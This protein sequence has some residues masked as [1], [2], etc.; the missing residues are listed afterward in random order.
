MPFPKFGAKFNFGTTI[1]T[2][3][4]DAIGAI[5]LYWH[6]FHRNRLRPGMN[7]SLP[8]SQ[9]DHVLQW[10]ENA[11][12]D[13]TLGFGAAVPSER[14]LA[15]QLG[16]SRNTVSA[17]MD[18]AERR[19][20][21]VTHSP[22]GRKRFVAG[23][24]DVRPVPMMRDSICV[25][26]GMGMAL[27]GADGVRLWSESLLSARLF[28]HLAAAG[29]NAMVVNDATLSESDVDRL[30]L[31]PP[32]GLL[33]TGTVNDTPLSRHI[34]R[35][36]R[37]A[38]VTAVAYGNHEGLRDMDRVYSD[39]RAGSREIVRWLIAQGCRH[40]RLFFPCPVNWHWMTERCEGY[41]EALRE[42]GLEAAPPL[43]YGPNVPFPSFAEEF[44]VARACAIATLLDLRAAGEP[45]DALVCMNDRFAKVAISALRAL[46]LDPG[47]DVLVA[48]YDNW[49][50]DDECDPYE[51][52]VPAVTLDRRSEA[53][54]IAMADLL[55]ARLDG[56]LPPEPQ[57]RVNPHRLVV[58][59]KP[60]KPAPPTRGAT[61]APAASTSLPSASAAAPTATTWGRLTPVP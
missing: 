55:L 4:I 2:F 43:V 19:G 40:I 15:L 18:E 36:C 51:R 1:F 3:G 56:R 44:R 60:P 24:D 10:L 6:R 50:H 13:G 30:F 38:G 42:A 11:I 7:S 21:V 9:R 31:I 59:W 52:G 45:F 57:A 8:T 20:I 16:V 49:T 34:L 28:A 48:G 5:A 53:A 47:R 29:R 25:V 23:E 27:D 35:R 12:A 33:V 39:H 46:D 41:A 37:Q 61:P 58:R 17:A 54:A 22:T 14:K 26:G 32:A